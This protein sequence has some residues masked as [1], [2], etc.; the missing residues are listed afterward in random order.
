MRL[1]IRKVQF[2][3]DSE[4]TAPSGETSREFLMSDKPLHVKA[5]LDKEVRGHTGPPAC[6]VK[7]LPQ[8][9]SSESPV[10]PGSH[11]TAA[12]LSVTGVLPRRARQCARQRHQ[13]L[14]Q[15]RQEHN[16]LR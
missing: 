12:V 9:H 8:A 6:C 3:P 15:E 7:H 13:Q 16:R 10:A 2:A 5:S 11:L 4:A 14:Q 1:M